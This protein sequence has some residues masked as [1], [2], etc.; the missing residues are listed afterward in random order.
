M[1]KQTK[2]T[3][4]DLTLELDNINTQLVKGRQNIPFNW[5]ITNNPSHI[6]SIAVTRYN[7]L[8]RSKGSIVQE[9]IRRWARI[10]RAVGLTS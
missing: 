1:F 2:A 4:V 5:F 3:L 9:I 8:L 6:E 10:R 7:N